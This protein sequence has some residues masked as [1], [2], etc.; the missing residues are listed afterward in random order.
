MEDEAYALEERY[1][2][3]FR[4]LY[5]DKEDLHDLCDSNFEERKA[6]TW[7]Q[8]N[9]KLSEQQ[10]QEINRTGYA[11]LNR[12]Q[13]EFVYGPGSPFNDS[14]AL[15]RLRPLLADNSTTVNKL[16]ELDIQRMAEMH[17]FDV[18]QNDVVLSPVLF[19][20]AILNPRRTSQPII[21]SPIVFSPTILSPTLMGPAILSPRVFSPT[22]SGGETI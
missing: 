20:P 4:G 22:V 19:N 14:Q 17:S 5:L 3:E 12:D 13:L 6:D 11:L 21:L 1:K 18:R 16:I 9:R 2:H 10:R 7:L 15:A 8:L